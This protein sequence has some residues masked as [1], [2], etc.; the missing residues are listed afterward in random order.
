MSS[1]VPALLH[2]EFEGHR[3]DT[4]WFNGKHYWLARDIGRLFEYS[5]DG[6]RLIKNIRD[7]WSDEFQDG[8]HYVILKGKELSDFKKFVQGVPKYGTPREDN[9]EFTF[10]K[11]IMLISSEGVDRVCLL[12]RKPVGLRLRD[13]LNFKVLPQIRQTGGYLPDGNSLVRSDKELDIRK[14]ELEHRIKQDERNAIN[15]LVDFLYDEGFIQNDIRAAYKVTAAEALTGRS[16]NVLKPTF[17][18]AK[19]KSPTDIGKDL[20]ISSQL[21]GRII[22]TIEINGQSLRGYPG[23]SRAI[24]NKAKGHHRMVDSYIY[25][26]QAQKMIADKYRERLAL[27]G[28]K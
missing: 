2:G 19:W 27:K 12:S 4:F 10:A 28:R 1:N 6:K 20:G 9:H 18:E 23:Y 3:V 17:V 5:S 22:S 14:M 26:E 21:V 7:E 13:W 11:S 15:E 25:S 8:V 16:L 24:I